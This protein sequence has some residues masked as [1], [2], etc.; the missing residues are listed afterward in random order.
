MPDP[1]M[2]IFSLILLLLAGCRDPLPPPTPAHLTQ[3][4]PALRIR[5]IK[6]AADQKTPAA[7]PQLI[8]CLEDEDPAVRFYAIQALKLITGTERGYNY[9]ADA[10]SRA[11]AVRRW[12]DWAIPETSRPSANSVVKQ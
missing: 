11:A 6:A 5:A 1:K 12:R 10:A 9:S 4:D 8:D 7:I 2:V 3:Q